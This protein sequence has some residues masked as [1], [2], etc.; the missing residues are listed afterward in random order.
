MTSRPPGARSF[1]ALQVDLL[2]AAE[3]AGERGAVLGEGRRIEDDEVEAPAAGRERAEDIERIAGERAQVPDPIQARM[4]G[5]LG[6]RPFGD[7]DGEHL[8]GEKCGVERKSTLVREAVEHRA[9][10]ERLERDPM[11]ALIEE[12]AGLLP[13]PRI[14]RELDRAFPNGDARGRLAVKLAHLAR[15]SF[16]SAHRGIVAEENRLRLDQVL[17]RGRDLG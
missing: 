13:V 4:L 9:R 15:Q 8:L 5:R 17:D 1:I 3:R 6:E 16:E 14:D 7:V 10:A 2:V 11:L 12:E